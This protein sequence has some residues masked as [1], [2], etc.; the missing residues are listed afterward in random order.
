MTSGTADTITMD[1][2]GAYKK[3]NSIL[4][5]MADSG[6]DALCIFEQ[7]I[8]KREELLA[9]PERECD[10]TRLQRAVNAA[11]RRTEGYPLQY[12]LGEW[13]FYGRTFK[14]GEG[15]L[16]PR[17]DTETLIDEAQR[18]IDSFDGKR[19]M[20]CADLCAG[21]GCIGITLER[22]NPGRLRM[23]AVEL[24]GDVFPYLV[25][26]IGRHGAEIV[27]IRG[28]IS[29]GVLLD[30]FIDDD[31]EEMGI[32]LI[33]SNPPY[34]SEKEMDELQKEVTFEPSM[35]L[36]GGADGL[37]FYRV[38]SRL[39]GEMLNK[40]GAIVFEIGETQRADVEKILLECGFCDI[41]T[42]QYAGMD[43]VISARKK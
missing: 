16:I 12:I 9:F 38:I 5:G 1:L 14:V 36:Y 43:R 2:N 37:Q 11:H 6:F 25:D 32:D 41:N 23:Y 26:N 28:D 24:S 19:R 29:N 22:N 33:V 30:N 39:W 3:I 42:V 21:S 13:E 20:V 31:G 4:S 35:A 40:G 7:F 10:E 27:M 34:L 18:I 17:P 15:V 8:T